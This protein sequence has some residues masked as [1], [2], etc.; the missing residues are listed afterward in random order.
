LVPAGQRILIYTTNSDRKGNS[1]ACHENY[2]MDR[3]M[4]FNHI[5]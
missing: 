2:L 4:P 5:V 3:N 1:Y